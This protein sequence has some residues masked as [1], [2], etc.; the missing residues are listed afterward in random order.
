VVTVSGTVFVDRS[1]KNKISE[2]LDRMVGLLKK[3]IN[4]VV[5]PEGTSTDGSM[6]R[7]FQ[8][9]FFQVPLAAG[10]PILPVKI[11]YLAIDG[12]KVNDINK[13]DLCWYGQVSFFNHLWN[14]FRFRSIDV[15]VEIHEK[16]DVTSYVNN[17]QDRKRMAQLCYDVICEASGTKRTLLPANGNG[18]G[19]TGKEEVSFS[20]KNAK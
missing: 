6:I 4:V 17:S 5:F 20:L 13:N 14:L 2:A 11:S 9:V 15:Q 18:N 16:I 8:T 12:I 10:I 7:P 1:R 19:Q 3:Q